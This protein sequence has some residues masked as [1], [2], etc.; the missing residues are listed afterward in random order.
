MLRAQ[1]PAKFLPFP[2]QP[3]PVQGEG[4]KS[5]VSDSKSVDWVPEQEK[6]LK[7]DI[8]GNKYLKGEVIPF[9]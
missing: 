8:L 2:P 7:F 1:L 9:A 6:Q 4:D 5:Q 3:S